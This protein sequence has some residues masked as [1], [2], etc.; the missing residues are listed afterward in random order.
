MK[1]FLSIIGSLCLIVP[2]YLFWLWIHAGN[3][4]G[5]YP[6]NVAL[7]HS[8]LPEILRG[9]YATSIIGFAFSALAVA[10]NGFQFSKKTKSF[11]L[12]SLIIIIIAGTLAFLNL[13][14][15]M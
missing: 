12:F 9:R 10:L 8:Y 13:W 5:D 11:K 3:L 4:A 7:Y 6:K 1:N 15:M 2:I 14:S